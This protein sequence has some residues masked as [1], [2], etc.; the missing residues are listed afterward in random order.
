MTL[1]II[2]A[3][4]VTAAV[5]DVVSDGIIGYIAIAITSGWIASKFTVDWQWMALTWIGCTGAGSVAY[6]Y[7]IAGVR[8]GVSKLEGK[9]HWKDTG[10]GAVGEKA[11]ARIIEGTL[12]LEWNGDLWPA[13][14]DRTTILDGDV[15]TITAFENGKLSV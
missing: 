8:K 11:K 13:E 1:E 10:S 2:I 6:F 4:L 12:M 15:V 3:I 7:C 14:S 5:I 9:A